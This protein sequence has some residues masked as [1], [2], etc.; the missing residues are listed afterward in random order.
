G[1]IDDP[2]MEIDIAVR[3]YGVPH[4]FS[5][6]ALDEAARLP[7]EVRPA[8]IRHRVDLRDVPLVTSDGED[9]RDFDDAVYCEPVKVGRGDGFR[10]IVAIA[11]VAHYVKPNDALDIGALERSTSRYFPR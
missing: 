4:E 11:D 6:A 9:A 7:D 8:D 3:K 10:L 5:G 1:D 2:G